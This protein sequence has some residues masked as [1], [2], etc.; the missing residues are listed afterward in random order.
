MVDEILSETRQSMARA[1]EAF[2]HEMSTVRTGR[3][4]TALLDNI[5]AEY[6]GAQVPLNQVATIGVPEPRLIVIQPWDKSAI[7]AIEKAIQTSNL[8][9][10]PSSD[11]TVIRLPIPQLTE[12]RR[13]ELVRVVRQMAEDSK[14][15]VRNARRD[16]NEMLKDGQKEGE[17]PEDDSRKGQDQVQKL[18]DDFVAEIDQLLARKEEEIMEV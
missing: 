12:E 7:P 3:A 6:Y 14:V 17:I 4:N 8:G 11:G 16:A 2:Q 15:S 9:L 13:S 1:V 18:T 10:T 5:R